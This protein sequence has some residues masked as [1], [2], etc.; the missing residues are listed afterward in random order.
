VTGKLTSVWPE[1]CKVKKKK[2]AGKKK[3]NKCAKGREKKAR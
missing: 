2:R 3:G 1:E